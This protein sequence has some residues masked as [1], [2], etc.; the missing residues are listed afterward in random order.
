MFSDHRARRDPRPLFPD[1]VEFGKSGGLS[2]G[3]EEKDNGR[4]GKK[5]TEEREKRK[6][7]EER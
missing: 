7:K 4:R 1:D 3:G 5:M 2:K 6:K